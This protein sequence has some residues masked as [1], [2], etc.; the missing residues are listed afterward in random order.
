MPMT[1]AQLRNALE[2]KDDEMEVEIEGIGGFS[3][4]LNRITGDE[5]DSGD[6]VVTLCWSD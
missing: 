6:L 1:V 3:S 2:D 4:P 5:N